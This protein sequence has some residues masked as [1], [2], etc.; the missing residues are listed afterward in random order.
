[1]Q[2]IVSRIDEPVPSQ[3]LLIWIIGSKERIGEYCFPD[4]ALYRLPACDPL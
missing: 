4:T 1:M 3:N 2:G